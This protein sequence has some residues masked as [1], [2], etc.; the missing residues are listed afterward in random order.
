MVV[1]S[2]EWG[3]N[4]PVVVAAATWV[5]VIGAPMMAWIFSGKV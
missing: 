4:N 5:Y 1:K 3:A 2:F